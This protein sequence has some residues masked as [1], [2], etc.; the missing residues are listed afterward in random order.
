MHT[1]KRSKRAGWAAFSRLKC[2]LQHRPISLAHRLYLW[3][4]CIHTIITYGITATNVTV[5]VLNE[6]QMITYQM[7]RTIFGNH[8]YRTRNTH[9]QV[10]VLHNHPHPLE[11]LHCLV[12][13]LWQ[14]IQRRRIDLDTN[15]FLQHI[16]WN[17]LPDLI[18][19]I[20]DCRQSRQMF[21]LRMTPH[22]YRC[23]IDASFAI[24][25]HTPSPT[26]VDTVPLT[27][28]IANIVLHPTT[29]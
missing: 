2:W 19:L 5:K 29:S 21:L 25:S 24:L 26:C 4:T 8:S 3:R 22:P 7:L 27:I 10:M 11:L 23:N 17:H 15:D 12:T 1:W 9:S 13:S 28:T 20:Q 6:Y 18:D 14:R 16:S